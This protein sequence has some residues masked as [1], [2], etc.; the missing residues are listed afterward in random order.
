MSRG[1]MIVGLLD[2]SRLAGHSWHS[3][4]IRRHLAILFCVALAGCATSSVESGRQQVV[5]PTQVSQVYSEVDLQMQLASAKPPSEEMVEDECLQFEYR[6]RIRKLMEPLVVVARRLYPDLGERGVVFQFE[7]APSSQAGVLSNAG[8]SIVALHGTQQ[9]ELPDS[10]LA[11]IVT[12]EMGHVIARHHDENSAASV[13]FSVLTQVL[14]P[15]AA[16]VKGLSTVL[17]STAIG[18]AATASAVSY[19]G[20][21]A[22]RTSY[23]TD[24]D[25]EAEKIAFRLMAEAGWDIYAVADEASRVVLKDGDERWIKSFSDSLQ[26]LDRLANGPRRRVFRAGPRPSNPLSVVPA[27][28]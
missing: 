9:L 7:V 22:L 5:V 14:F 23:R 18:S 2:M 17:P 3:M 27:P 25:R 28:A 6:R 8:G 13:M 4:S 11:F 16:L 12:R 21:N 15:A 10:V 1:P 24:H 19:M 20:A 26:Q